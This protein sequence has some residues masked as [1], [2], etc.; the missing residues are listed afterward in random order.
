MA[1]VQKCFPAKRKRAPQRDKSGALAA[2]GT[3]LMQGAPD[4]AGSVV[5]SKGLQQPVPAVRDWNS[6]ALDALLGIVQHAAAD[7]KARKK[8]AFKIAEFLLPKVGKKPKALPDE[9]E[10]SVNPNLAGTYRD[11]QLEVRALVNEPSRKIPAIAEKIKKLEARSEAVQRRFL[12]PCPTR[13]K[14]EA[15]TNDYLRLMQFTSARD[16]GAALTEVQKAEEAYVKL[17]VDLFANSP[18]SIARRRRRAL[19]DAERFFRQ[20]R[21]FGDLVVKAPS[22]KERND[23][24]LLRWLYPKPS[25]NGAETRP[26]EPKAS[27]I[28]QPEPKAVESDLDPLDYHPFRDE[29]ASTNGNFYPPDSKVRPVGVITETWSGPWSGLDRPTNPPSYSSSVP[30]SDPIQTGPKQSR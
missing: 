15:A 1:V 27:K 4:K 6:Q 25:P 29:W 9:Y 13:Y 5:L 12:V 26:G 17:R 3:T 8:A 2:I 24:E 18:E 7:P 14:N 16:N 21:F 28:N 19:E 22:R 23:L 10:F 30:A 11:M 20:A